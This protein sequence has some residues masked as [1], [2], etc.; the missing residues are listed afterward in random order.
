MRSSYTWMLGC[1]V[2]RMW[3]D[4]HGLI[5]FSIGVNRWARFDET[6]TSVARNISGR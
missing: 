3:R 1:V 4:I 2:P 5:L 6:R